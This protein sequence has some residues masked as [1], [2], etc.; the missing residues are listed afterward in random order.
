MNSDEILKA[1][2][3]P[4]RRD[5]LRWLKTPAQEFAEQS[6]P[7]EWG[8]CVGRICERAGLSQ[9]TVSAHLAVLQ[10]AGLVTSHKVGQWI[11]I[12]RNEPV[13]AAFVAQLAGDL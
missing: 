12:K 5:I 9:S 7:L 10:R 2:A 4:L 3:N 13:I 1:L 8:V 6:H 11:F